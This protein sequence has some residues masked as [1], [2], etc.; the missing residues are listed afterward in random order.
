MIMTDKQIYAYIGE[1][2]NYTDRLA[3]ASDVSI[4]VYDA[5]DCS[6]DIDQDF[7]EQVAR[8]WDVVCMSFRG[9]LKLAGLS[10]TKLSQKYC[11]PLKTV[12]NW[13]ASGKEYRECPVY[14]RLMIAEI[15]GYL[16]VRSK[17]GI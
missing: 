14:T 2:K 15:S 12:Q 17:N 3:F 7:M 1:A 6:E 8:L 4:S 10:Q 11:I 5:A 16:N 13:C 9:F